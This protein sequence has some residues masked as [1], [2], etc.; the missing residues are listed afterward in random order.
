MF[1]L[2]RQDLKALAGQQN[3][4]KVSIILPLTRET[5]RADRNRIRLLG[6][7][8]E[9]EALLLSQGVDER[10]PCVLL[11]PVMSMIETDPT[12]QNRGDAIVILLSRGAIRRYPVPARLQKAVWAGD[13]FYLKPLLCVL[14]GSS[15]GHLDILVTGR[16]AHPD[17]LTAKK[18]RER[19]WRRVEPRSHATR[20]ESFGQFR[21]LRETAATSDRIETVVP[22]A[23]DGRVDTLF[24][25]SDQTC[26]GRFDPYSRVVTEHRRRANGDWDLLDLAAQHCLLHDSTIH[27]LPQEELPSPSPMAGILRA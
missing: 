11:K 3:G 23:F 10:V 16:N 19:A 13:R 12:W 21:A 2:S 6:L 9:A 17:E 1:P 14:T 7:L 26:W 27:V 8:R 25:A 22:A 18:L 20:T 24:V 5:G 15:R 4:K